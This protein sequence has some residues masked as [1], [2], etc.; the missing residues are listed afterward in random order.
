MVLDVIG[1]A[2][3]E[4]GKFDEAQL[5]AQRALDLAKAAKMK[6]LEPIEQRLEL[7]QKHRPWRESFRATN[8]PA[9]N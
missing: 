6:N 3:A 2:C 8:A 9:K 7:Y 5:A 4:M 1:M